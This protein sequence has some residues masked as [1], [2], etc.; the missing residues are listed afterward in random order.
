MHHWPITYVAF[1]FNKGMTT[2]VEAWIL[3]SI[4]ITDILIS[5]AMHTHYILTCHTP[6][7]RFTHLLHA[8]RT[9]DLVRYV[10]SKVPLSVELFLC[11][12]FVPPILLLTLA[13]P[14]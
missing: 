5:S 1:G 14:P 6:Y 3:I 2:I 12:C 11:H 4:T 8:H 10:L 13:I 9:S 7:E